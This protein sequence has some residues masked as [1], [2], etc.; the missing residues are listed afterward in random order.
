MVWTDVKK[1]Y[2]NIQQ[3]CIIRV[4]DLLEVPEWIIN[5]IRE[6]MKSW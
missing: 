6:A 2:D 4:F 5:F 3:R 1:A